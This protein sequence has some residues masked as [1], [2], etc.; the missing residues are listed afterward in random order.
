MGHRADHALL[1]MQFTFP[2]VGEGITEGKLVS[3]HTKAGQS[4]KEDDVLAEIETDKALV[5]IPSP[6]SG[7][8]TKLYGSVGDIIKVGT[9]LAD[10]D[11]GGAP[12]AEKNDAQQPQQSTA[13]STAPPNTTQATPIPA[14]PTAS[15][16]V[17]STGGMAIPSTRRFAQEHGLDI[18]N[19]HGTGIHGEVTMDD[20]H[21]A[22]DGK[23]GTSTPTG[24]A[25]TGA[26]GIASPS[27]RQYAREHDIDLHTVTGTGPGG[28]IEKND[29]DKGSH[30]SAPAPSPRATGGRTEAMSGMRKAIARHMQEAWKTP[31]VWHMERVD[32]TPLV[33]IRETLKQKSP[34]TK[35]T[36]LPFIIKA[37]IEALKEHPEFNARLDME[38]GEITYL[39]E[40]HFG[41]AVD[42]PEGVLVPVVRDADKKDILT[43][44]QEI[45]AY[46]HAAR[47]RKLSVSDM[48]G[49]TLTITNIGSIGGD[50]FTP[51][52]N[53]PE[54]AILGVGRMGPEPVVNKESGAIE[55]RHILRMTL[56]FDHRITD[57]ANAAKFM[58]TIKRY[59][60]AP[61]LWYL[62]IR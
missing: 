41:I 5:E 27:T 44:A 14:P 26:A 21:H 15:P 40:R 6:V 36:Y 51:L 47:D 43:I 7:T 59:L 9:P 35:I 2:D 37:T 42:T 29:L 17:T 10:F 57:G 30:P 11:T 45:V 50:Y 4:I 54:V 46:A 52:L 13:A 49:S 60:E 28:R 34:D 56:G 61:E 58:N 18:A 39:A 22:L 32:I 8:V 31:T 20:V 1:I 33:T 25:P 62:E 12:T 19:I 24:P 3:W 53:S 38:R 16:S 23:R 55:T 48:K